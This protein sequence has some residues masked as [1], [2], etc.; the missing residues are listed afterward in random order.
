MTKTAI[1]EGIIV[2]AI[3]GTVLVIVSTVGLFLLTTMG[4]VFW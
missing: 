2:T 4:N 3:M 1:A